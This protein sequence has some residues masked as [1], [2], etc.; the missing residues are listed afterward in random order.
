MPIHKYNT[1]NKNLFG[2]VKGRFHIISKSKGYENNELGACVGQRSQFTFGL[3][4]V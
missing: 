1:T 4:F 2:F 3:R